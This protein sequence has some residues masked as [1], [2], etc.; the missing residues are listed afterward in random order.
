MAPLT[1][2]TVAAEGGRRGADS[3]SGAQCRLAEGRGE[4]LRPRC[5]TSRTEGECR[6]DNLSPVPCALSRS[7]PP[8]S[9]ALL[10]PPLLPASAGLRAS[11]RSQSAR[12][13]IA[14]QHPV[15]VIAQ[16]VA[17]PQS[18][19]L[20]SLSLSLSLSLSMRCIVFFSLA[21]LKYAWYDRA[22]LFCPVHNVF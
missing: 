19:T 2:C 4:R 21:K 17:G 14:R 1:G 11:H 6:G 13:H 16:H 8:L 18:S 10:S 15:T 20:S 7:P 12:R 9:P 22:V 5:A 3:H